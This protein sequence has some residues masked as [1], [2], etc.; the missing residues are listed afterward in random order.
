MIRKREVWNLADSNFAMREGEGMGSLKLASKAADR[1]RLGACIDI[2]QPKS[3]E[4]RHWSPPGPL[5]LEPK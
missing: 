2:L 5:T 1:T 4:K 3:P